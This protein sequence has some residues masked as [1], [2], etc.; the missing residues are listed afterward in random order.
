[1]T[2]AANNNDDN[3]IIEPDVKIQDT[4]EPDAD[5]DLDW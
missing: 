3:E 2:T 1:M 4:P 5:W